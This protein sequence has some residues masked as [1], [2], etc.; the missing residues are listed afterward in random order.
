MFPLVGLYI[1]PNVATQTCVFQS[2]SSE[3]QRNLLGLRLWPSA[4][5]HLAEMLPEEGA[6][7]PHSLLCF[8]RPS[9]LLLGSSKGNTVFQ[10]RCLSMTL[11]LS[12]QEVLIQMK[13]ET[14]EPVPTLRSLNRLCL[15][16]MWL[17]ALGIRIQPRCSPTMCLSPTLCHSSTLSLTSQARNS[18]CT[19]IKY[20]LCAGI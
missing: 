1:A 14:S 18:G 20:L 3:L 11:L 12:P 10:A 4:T 16:A 2:L 5:E 7:P 6:P 13:M 8:S 17:Q 19:F 15:K 9:A